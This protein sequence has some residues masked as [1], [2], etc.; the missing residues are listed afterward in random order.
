MCKK[1]VEVDNIQ[2]S[3][4]CREY[5]RKQQKQIIC[6][7]IVEVDNMQEKSRSR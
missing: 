4:R 5:T 7:K 2:E 1:I 3:S 6:K